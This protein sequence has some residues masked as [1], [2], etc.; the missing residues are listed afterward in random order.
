MK[1]IDLIVIGMF[2]LITVISLWVVF[3][4]RK[5]KLAKDGKRKSEMF[6]DANGD[7][8]STRLKSYLMMLVFFVINLMVF[9]VVLNDL[10]FLSGA[11]GLQFLFMFL[12]FDLFMLI[13]IF[14][15]SQLNKTA[16]I[17]KL[18]ELAKPPAVKQIEAETKQIE[19]EKPTP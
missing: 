18:I 5:N 4:G 7:D 19:A 16:E 11:N 3:S 15:P 10:N 9:S 2:A 12:I 13:A 17:T 6:E 14:V 8:S 1:T